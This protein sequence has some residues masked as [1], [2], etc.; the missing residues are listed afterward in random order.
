MRDNELGEIAKSTRTVAIAI[1]GGFDRALCVLTPLLWKLRGCYAGKGVP[2]GGKVCELKSERLRLD[3]S[4][5]ADSFELRDK[6]ARVRKGAGPHTRNRWRASELAGSLLKEDDIALLWAGPNSRYEAP[7]GPQHATD[8]A[9]RGLPINDVHHAEAGEH[10]VKGVA[11]DRNTLGT[12]LQQLDIITALSDEAASGEGQH[13]SA[14]IYANDFAV[15]AHPHGCPPSYGTSPC[16]KVKDVFAGR[17]PCPRYDSVDHRREP[18]VDLAKVDLRD[19][20]PNANLPRKTFPV[21]IRIDHGPPPLLY[22]RSAAG[23][24]HNCHR[25][26]TAA[27]AVRVPGAPTLPTF[28]GLNIQF[29]PILTAGR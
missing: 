25:S 16:A 17:Q 11:I 9:R 12:P 7:A 10:D 27:L 14:D 2:G 8:F 1:H 3:L 19:S 23:S 5:K 15:W 13:V 24:L 22:F 26:A 20:I 21:L 28:H 4:V 18:P 29:A 6:W